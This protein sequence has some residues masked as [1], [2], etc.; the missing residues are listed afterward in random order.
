MHR[1][2]MIQTRLAA[3]ALSW[4]AACL[5]SLLPALPA[6]VH[7]QDPAAERRSDAVTLNFVNAD[8]P[9]VVKAIGGSLGKNFFIHARGHRNL[10]IVSPAPGSQG[11]AYPIL[12]SALRAHGCVAGAE[13]GGAESIPRA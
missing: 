6:I 4:F 7:A 3:C 8:I 5:A 11:L 2:S 1:K 10:N 9:S 12:L 13:P